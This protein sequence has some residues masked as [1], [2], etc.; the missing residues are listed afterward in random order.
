MLK[1]TRH[2][3]SFSKEY[4]TS[5]LGRTSGQ[6]AGAMLDGTKPM[7]NQSTTVD[8]PSKT[9]SA[10]RPMHA[11]IALGLVL[12][13]GLAQTGL[14]QTAT[15]T[16]LSLSNNY[17]VT[18]D[19]VVG[20]WAKTSSVKIS[21]TLMSTGTIKIPDA[22]AYA[23]DVPLQQ[24]PAGADIVAAFLYW[25]SVESS[26]TYAGQN[27]S[28]R[29][30]PITG[31]IL[32]NPNAPVSWSS[33]GCAGSSQGSKT[34]VAYRADVTALLPVDSNGNVQPN[35]SYQVSLPDTGK[36]GQPPYTLGAT[37]VIIY[38]L[39]APTVPLNAVVIYDGA[40]APSNTSQTV[41]LP[42]LGFFQAGND[43]SLPIVAKI[44]HIVGNGQSNKLEQV[45]FNNYDANGNLLHSTW[46]PSVYGTNPPFPGN[47]N[48][49]WDNPTWFP[50]AYATTPSGASAVQAD[51]SSETTLVIPSSTNK[52]CVSWGAVILSTT[53]QDR[54]HDGLLDVWKTNQG[55]CDAGA[56]PGLSTQGTCPLRASDPSWVALPGAHSPGQ[57]NQ[58]VFIQLDYMC[59]KVISHSDGTTTCDP[60]GV[61]YEPDQQAISDLTNAFTSNGHNINVHVVPDD[62]N[63]ILAQTC[64]D[65]LSVSPPQYCPFP[66]QA[67]V[68]GWKAGFAFLKSQPLNYS[69]ETS[70][71]TRTPPG[72][73][74]GTGPLCVRRFQPGR[75]L[76]YHEVIFGNASAVPNWS[77]LD[78]SLTSVVASGNTFTFTT[79]NPHG[80]VPD[81]GDSGVPN[82]RVTVS[83]AISNPNLNGTYLV[84]SA[85]TPTTFK[86]Q[87][88]N[89]TTA[90]TQS[91]DPYFSITS[92]SV[93]T[94][95]GV[96]DVGGADSLVSLGLW[97]A[98]GQT[99]PV[100]SGT[101]M[102][103]LGH[104]LGLTHGGYARVP[105]SSGYGD[106]FTFEPNCKPNFQSVMNYLFQVDLLDGVLDYSEQG[107]SVLD[108][109]SAS[110]SGVLANAIHPTTKWYA[111]NQAFGSPA[112]RHCDGTPLLRTDQPMFRVQGSLFP[113]DTVAW[114]ANQDIN[115]DGKI[116]TSLQGYDDWANI[117]LRQIGAT[118]N[119]FWLAGA[120]RL[121]GGAPRLGGGAPRLGGGAPRLGGGAPR[122]GG[123]V[124]EI[125]FP[126]ANSVVR[127]PSNLSATLTSSNT[128]QL[129]WAP[130][131]FGQSMIA[132]F[133]IYRAVNGAAFSQPPYATV[134]VSGTPLPLPSP[135]TFTDTR[136]SCAAYTYFV[137]T[138][139]TDGRESVPSNTSAPISA[140]CTFVGFVS[141]LTTAGTISAPSFSGIEKQGSA[142]PIKWELLDS[143]GNVI[144]DLST[145]KLMQACPT[146]D[147]TVPPA[148]STIPP[149]VLLYSP[150][151]GAKGNSTFRFSSPQ[152]IF[153][154]DT[155]STIGSAAGFFTIEVTLS[156]GSA[157]KATTIQFK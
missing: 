98:D 17:I 1:H 152:F 59:T 154:W 23:N 104:S 46:L 135:F 28:F 64:T 9:L 94:G 16:P 50:N 44:T 109:S 151:T 100:E 20:G 111:P 124:G 57:G 45:Y 15:P 85:P 107:L 89:A 62:N 25:E 53:V 51:E 84:Q 6:G 103:E 142:V 92:G 110:P 7:R 18:G 56:N 67:G 36:A 27:G 47:Y 126:T 24:V 75:R 76:S 116:E 120:P 30:Y 108:E 54:D 19:Y 49:S 141:P 96:S 95:S 39:L 21:G 38:R 97:G 26:G 13:F 101:L 48:G 139:L 112:T 5:P 58:D 66:G 52:G 130:P 123:G 55:Y 11:A 3:P 133:N 136:V 156:D 61:S 37:L 2:L 41:T 8:G 87:I 73:T 35:T 157:V 86:I 125:T 148:S 14:A 65:N 22:G 140:P 145:L 81:P 127:S 138:V 90:P 12:V 70:C 129:S 155:S 72:G 33:G 122:L 119:D 60:T 29:G 113:T 40:Y 31:T 132:A 105:D 80:L 147:S 146:T 34:I 78:G 79:L 134:T 118:G 153:N 4:V 117:D 82:G 114:A 106:D 121:G 68:V 69:D 143:S 42:M 115:F 93:G 102:H 32:G 63:V 144:S 10:R 83:D 43:Q 128:V 137:T 71:E 131:T 74:A 77:F 91:S 88:A 150:T 149:C 99:V